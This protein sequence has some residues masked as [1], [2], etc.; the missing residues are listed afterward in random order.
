MELK[1]DIRLKNHGHLN[2]WLYKEELG[3]ET[4][5]TLCVQGVDVATLHGKA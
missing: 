3:L 2:F 1:I 4:G 5:R